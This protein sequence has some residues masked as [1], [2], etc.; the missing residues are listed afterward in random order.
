MPAQESFTLASYNL[1]GYLDAATGSRPAKAEAA[2]R[3]VH[4]SML[5]VGADVV[6]L[7]EV[8]SVSALLSL[9]EALKRGGLDYPH[10]E[11]V[12]GYDTNIFVA[13]LSRFPFTGRQPHTNE[14]FLLYGRRFRV[15]RGFAEVEVRVSE[16]YR[17]TL[18]TAHL[19]SRRESA[20]ADQAELREQEALRLRRIVD[21][22]LQARPEVNLAVLGDLN[23][24]PDS[25]PLRILLARGKRNALVDT[26]PAEGDDGNSFETDSRRDSRRV[27]WTHFY[28]KE[29]VYSRI[30]YILVSRGMAR[31]WDPGGSYVLRTPDWGVGSDHRPIVARFLSMD[32]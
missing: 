25:A 21:A 7:Q 14:G 31:E 8:G 22:R 23:D 28:A 20:S 16:R 30:D 17:F 32:R 15:S 26:R 6:A 29:D 10:W 11:L 9:R 2:R 1:E 24:H 4:E 13:V 19:K 27:T 3:K 18:I 12:S 5:A